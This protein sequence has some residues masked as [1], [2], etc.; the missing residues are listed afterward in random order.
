MPEVKAERVSHRQRQALETRRLIAQAA[1]ALFSEH[2][3]AALKAHEKT[4]AMD[5]VPGRNEVRGP[6]RRPSG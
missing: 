4:S 1:R 5:L 3:Y 6:V 2:G